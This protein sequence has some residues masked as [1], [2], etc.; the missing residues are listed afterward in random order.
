MFFLVIDLKRGWATRVV[1]PLIA[2]RAGSRADILGLGSP[3]L[4]FS[5]LLYLT[6]PLNGVNNLLRFLIGIF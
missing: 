6:A 4:H 3:P 5:T 1:H 2:N